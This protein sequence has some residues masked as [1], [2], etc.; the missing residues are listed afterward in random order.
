MF[1]IKFLFGFNWSI[2][3]QLV[4]FGFSLWYN[5][6]YMKYINSLDS[7]VIYTLLCM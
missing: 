6:G 1:Q 7:N 3:F 5:R 4:L 2:W